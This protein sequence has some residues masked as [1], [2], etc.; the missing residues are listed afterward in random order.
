MRIILP[1]VLMFFCQYGFSQNLGKN[2]RE[3][4]Y[5]DF[6]DCGLVTQYAGNKI[7][8]NC[9]TNA[10][11]VLF[12]EDLSVSRRLGYSKYN[13]TSL[14]DSKHIRGMWSFDALDGTKYMVVESS[15]SLF[16]TT[17]G[18]FKQIVS[19]IA[20]NSTNDLNCVQSLGSLWCT[21][22]IDPLLS[23]DGS[24]LTFWENAPR[25]KLI[26]TFRNRLI[27]GD[28]TGEKT[29]IL[30]SGEGDGTDWNLVI[31][32]QSTSPA[33][34]DISGVNDGD[35]I[36]CLMGQYQ[37]AYIIGRK[38]D[39]WAF[40]GTSRDDFT[41]RQISNEIGCKEQR[42]VKEKNNCL[43]WLSNRGVEQ[44][45][46]TTIN[47]ASD[48]IRDQIDQIIQSAGNSLSKT[49]DTDTEW[50]AGLANSVF[51]SSS[52][53]L[54]S[55]VPSSWSHLDTQAYDWNNGTFDNIDSTTIN[56]SIIL[57]Y[58]DANEVFDDF[59]QLNFENPHWGILSGSWSALNGNAHLLGQGTGEII[60]STFTWYG[61]SIEY[62]MYQSGADF[63][64]VMSA[65]NGTR[66]FIQT[67]PT[68][69]STYH[70][71]V[72]VSNDS[73]QYD[74]CDSTIA[75]PQNAVSHFKIS[76]IPGGGWNFSTSYGINISSVVNGNEYVP[77]GIGNIY[78]LDLS[79]I[80][81]LGSDPFWDNIKIN[82][83]SGTWISPILDTTFPDPIGGVFNFD[84]TVPLDSTIAYS[85][86]GSTANDGGGFTTWDLVSTTTSGA[87]KIPLDGKEF[88]QYKADFS[89]QISTQ[90]PELNSAELNAV[91]TGYYINDCVNAG[92][93][94]SWGNFRVTDLISGDSSINY[95]VSTGTSCNEVT[96]S[97]ATWQSQIPN[98]Q[99]SIDTAPYLGI[100]EILNPTS[101][102]DTTKVLSQT[103]EWNQGSNRPPVSAEVY[104]D[105]YYLFYTT[106]TTGSGNDTVLILD[107]NNKWSKF[108]DIY[109]YSSAIVNNYLYT[110]DSKDSGYVYLQ[111]IGTQDN[112][113]QFSFDIKTNDYDYGNPVEEKLLKR[114][115]L[116][117]KTEDYSGQNINLT[118][119]Y[120][121]NGSTT[122]YSLGAVPLNEA[123]EN[124]YFVAKFPAIIGQQSAFN[125]LS[126]EISYTGDEGPLGV[127]GIKVIYEPLTW[128]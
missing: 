122:A 118:L 93:V 14:T 74:I 96:R 49:Y 91:S 66:L 106:S 20:F 44:Y 101:S 102:T 6:S 28:I 69:K 26:G 61:G 71:Y 108:D 7:P 5:P 25:G 100:K 83:K 4:N 37:D 124:G 47:R 67:N 84:N 85:V 68:T 62:D 9:L 30:L 92:P 39:L 58:K 65:T 12:D 110:G 87:Y 75:P 40:Y 59:S 11:N 52:I 125:W 126:L 21:N 31:P 1:L 33:S 63:L 107:K 38:S 18:N 112:T 3:F 95:Y 127:Y 114:V 46:G 19:T 80:S 45:C 70:T 88:W 98:S 51:T 34:I 121:I 22:G 15:T 99:I 79:K 16:Y 29:R 117:L 111:D 115:Y 13:A 50:G 32:G 53:E 56:G 64:Q 2:E 36:T 120:Y 89:T 90:I 55:I 72:W 97:T 54:G 76:F 43:V 60:N 27:I 24:N 10:D 8:P 113:N 73:G 48:A 94:T 77:T 123:P 103:I 17:D 42:S 105:R 104:K 128:E 109:A 35:E 78:E 119:K 41:L 86:R 23:W 57:D 116:Y 82:K 81:G